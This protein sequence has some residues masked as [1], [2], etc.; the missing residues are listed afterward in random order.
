MSFIMVFFNHDTVS[1]EKVVLLPIRPLPVIMRRLPKAPFTSHVLTRRSR[2]ITLQVTT[3][4]PHTASR[5]S[6]FCKMPRSIPPQ[7]VHDRE[8]RQTAGRSDLAHDQ[9]RYGS[10]GLLSARHVPF[11]TCGDTWRASELPIL[12]LTLLHVTDWLTE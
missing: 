5:H 3:L 12:S 1:Q 7:Y 8:D 10:S 2:H 4:S 9:T 6:Q 11:V